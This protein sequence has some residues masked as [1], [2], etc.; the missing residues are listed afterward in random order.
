MSWSNKYHSYAFRITSRIC[1]FKYLLLEILT[2]FKFTIYFSMFRRPIF[3]LT[4]V[5]SKEY[6]CFSLGSNNP[7][8]L[9]WFLKAAVCVG[10]IHW[11]LPPCCEGSRSLSPRPWGPQCHASA[12]LGTGSPQ[13]CRGTL[14]GGPTRGHRSVERVTLQYCKRGSSP[15]PP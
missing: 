8:Y 9:L 3:M 1:A 14:T 4:S 13:Y 15:A 2:P 6:M 12:L 5:A 11:L 7:P 10:T